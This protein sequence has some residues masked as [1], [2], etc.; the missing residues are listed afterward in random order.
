MLPFRQ[1]VAGMLQGKRADIV[2]C[3]HAR[4][5]LHALFLIQGLHFGKGLP[6]FNLFADQIMLAG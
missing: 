1:H 5:L 3:Q 2:T 4:Y 6:L